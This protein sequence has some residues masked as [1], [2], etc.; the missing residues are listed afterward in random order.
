MT[1]NLKIQLIQRQ[2]MNTSNLKMGI[3]RQRRKLR[4]KTKNQPLWKHKPEYL[5]I[6]TLIDAKMCMYVFVLVFLFNLI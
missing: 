2:R 3:Q 1:K 4:W 6:Y 5:D